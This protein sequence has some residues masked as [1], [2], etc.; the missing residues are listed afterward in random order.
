MKFIAY[1]RISEKLGMGRNV[2][3]SSVLRH[4]AQEG[5]KLIREF[6]EPVA[7]L[8]KVGEI[9][10]AAVQQCRREKAVLVVPG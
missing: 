5:G 9:F 4:V 7:D 8:A 6:S 10:E 2:Q 3:R 1:Y